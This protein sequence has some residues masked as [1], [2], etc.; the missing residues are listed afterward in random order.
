M[1]LGFRP[2]ARIIYS[3]ELISCSRIDALMRLQ[4]LAGLSQVTCA[5][6]FSKIGIASALFRV[7]KGGR[8]I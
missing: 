6:Q 7:E 5:I 2:D 1:H 8:G 4:G 3:K